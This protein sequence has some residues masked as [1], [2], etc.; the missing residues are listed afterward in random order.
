ML[1]THKM[2]QFRH[3][4]LRLRDLEG[5]R[6]VLAQRQRQLRHSLYNRSHKYTMT[7]FLMYQLTWL[8]LKDG[9]HLVLQHCVGELLLL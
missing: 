7:S 5:L 4:Q 6:L 9:L 1:Q 8:T 2:G 3:A